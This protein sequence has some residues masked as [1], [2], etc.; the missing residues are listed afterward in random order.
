MDSKTLASYID[1]TLLKADATEDEILKICQEA[2]EF[3]FKSVCVNPY[4]VPFARNHTKAKVCS[5]IGF[6][7]GAQPVEL[8]IR[9]AAYCLQNG[10]DEID[11]VI[12]L[13]YPK[14]GDFTALL[15][16]I[17]QIV[18]ASSPAI[19]KVIL[20]TTLLSKSEKIEATKTAVKAGAHFVKTSTGFNGG[21][22]KEDVILLKETV[23]DQCLIKASGGIRT[24]EDALNFISLGAN[25]IGTSS[26]VKIV[27]P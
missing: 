12:N 17:S 6:P 13:S 11:M 3:G 15:A 2:D 9:E 16:E 5:V 4:W 26:G 23:K 14:S 20:E 8:K 21:A 27:C 19:V 18:V 24:K 10:A 7:L 1:H 25:R 22:T